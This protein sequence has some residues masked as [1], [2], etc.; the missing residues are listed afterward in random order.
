[1]AR[2]LRVAHIALVHEDLD[3]ALRFWRDG[4]G[5]TVQRIADEPHEGVRVAFLPVGDDEIEIV[6]PQRADTGVARF[7]AKRG[8]G[9]HHLCLEVDNLPAMLAK[10]RQQGFELIHEQPQVTRDGRRYAFLHPRSTGGVLVELY[11][12]NTSVPATDAR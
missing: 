6:V 2:V 1:M 7:L 10:L 8:P 9:M 3:A 4:L 12:A 5:L 11:E